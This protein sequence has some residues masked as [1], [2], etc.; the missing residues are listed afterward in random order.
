MG[1]DF[2]RGYVRRVLD[3]QLDVLLPQ[4]PA[5]LLDGPKAV[6]KTRTAE[7][8]A[9][10]VWSL[11]RPAVASVV[12][13][14]P[15]AA[16]KAAPPV[17]FDEYQ[18]VDGLWDEVKD[19]VDRDLTPS[20]VLLTGSAPPPGAHSG[21]GRIPSLRMRPLTLHERGMSVPTVSLAQ[22]S[23]GS[24]TVT[25][26][27]PLRLADYTGAILQSGLPGLQ[28]LTGAALQ[29]QLDG[30]LERIV[31]RD[32][33]DA[34]LKV[35]RPATLTAWLRAY[36]AAVATPTAWDKIRDA[37]SPGQGDKPAK[38]TTLPYVDVL[39]HLR[40]LD[41]LPAWTPSR[42]HLD[43]LTQAPKHHLADPAL[44]AR[45]VGM[46]AASLLTGAG[47]VFT[48][49]DGTYL[50]QLF[51]SLATMTVRVF[52]GPVTASVSH[53]RL[54]SGRREV[55]LIVERDEDRA[56]VAFEVKL[57]ADVTDADVKHLVWLR[58]QLGDQVV[59]LAVLTPG[60]HAYRRRDG[61]A[62]IPLGLLGP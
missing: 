57:A 17:L 30:Y 47:D 62:V 8:R 48:P 42:N 33:P 44:A 21:A 3:D 55:D 1:N 12:A 39:T 36:A 38:T 56:I 28:H 49:K 54:G 31:D 61:V 41:E 9:R 46:T 13:A 43:R 16:I 50:G 4:L 27:C 35:R 6:G 25:G 51:E 52:A 24:A 34:G 59:D 5:L 18:K 23:T 26:T 60:E 53:L 15:V 32:V 11:H 10:S 7:Q 2:R 45:L 58:E 40:I 19:F 20:R 22:M 14:D 29:A 37:A